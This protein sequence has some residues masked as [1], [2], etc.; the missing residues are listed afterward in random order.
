MGGGRSQGGMGGLRLTNRSEAGSTS[1][2][3]DTHVFFEPG[4][5]IRKTR[6][7]VGGKLI[8]LSTGERGGEYPSSS[9]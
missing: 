8:S 5:S 6:P 7:D 2:G 4:W 3:V 9:T 1:S